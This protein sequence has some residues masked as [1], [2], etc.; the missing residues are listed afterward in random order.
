MNI[1]WKLRLQSKSFWIGVIG[2]I[3]LIAQFVCSN[4]GIKF[5]TAGLNALL[6]AVLTFVT[7]LG[8]VSDTSTPDIGDSAVTLAKTDINQTAE[9]IVKGE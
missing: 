4:Y 7:G 6:T 2:L 1:N 9:Q 5:D 3:M 8:V